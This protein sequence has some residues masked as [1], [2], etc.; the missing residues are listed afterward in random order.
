LLVLWPHRRPALHRSL[1]LAVA[2]VA[3]PTFLY[4]NS[5]WFQFGYRFSLDY[6][7]LLIVLI[8]VGGR[9][10]TRVA[11]GLIIAGVIINLFGALTFNR[12][13]H[14]YRGDSATYNV[15]IRH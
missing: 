10:L 4:Q 8:A 13:H 2:L 11:K 14:Y 5:G 6:M 9:P 1:W 12:D 15:V 7:A 3:I